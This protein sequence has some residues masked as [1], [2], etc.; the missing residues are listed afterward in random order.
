[1]CDLVLKI[2][3]EMKIQCIKQK[4]LVAYLEESQP[5]VSRWMSLNDSIRQNIP[6]TILAKIS[7]LLNVDIKYLLCMQEEKQKINHTANNEDY[8]MLLSYDIR[9]GAGAEGYL[10]DMPESTKI[11]VA[12]K[13]LNGSNPDFLHIIQVAGDSMEPTISDSDWLIVDMISNGKTNRMFE[14]V[15]GIYLVNIDGYIQIKRLEFRGTK[16]VDIISDNQ[17]YTRRNTLEDNLDLEIL[18]KL[19][20]QVK[21][22]GAL[23]ITNLDS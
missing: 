19:F 1:M 20:K 7:D 10:P 21:D 17:I 15:P 22:L 12:N 23:T 14:K 8:T 16:G 11:P 2:R 6:N 13:L 18:G 3:E 5:N 4:D 9:A